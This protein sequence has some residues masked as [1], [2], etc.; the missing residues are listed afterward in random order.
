MFFKT[1]DGAFIG[2]VAPSASF[3][4][5]VAQNYEIPDVLTLRLEVDGTSTT[6]ELGNTKENC[7]SFLLEEIN[8]FYEA[9]AGEQRALRSGYKP[10]ASETLFT[11]RNYNYE[12]KEG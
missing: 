3:T 1:E 9:F 12:R 4:L 5:S 7:R 8:R 6:I 2:R 10:P 11:F